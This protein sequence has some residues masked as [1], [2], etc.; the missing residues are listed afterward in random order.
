MVYVPH[1]RIMR[2]YVKLNFIH[3]IMYTA[4]SYLSLFVLD[5]VIVL[6]MIIF[7]IQFIPIYALA[8]D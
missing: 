4:N 6:N 7:H 2:D 1:K 3:L 8:G 5:T